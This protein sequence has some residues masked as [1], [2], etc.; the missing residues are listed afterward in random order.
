MNGGASGPG[1][2]E[3]GIDTTGLSK[4]S[5]CCG[6]VTRRNVCSF[7]SF[8]RRSSLRHSVSSPCQRYWPNA[9]AQLKLR[10]TTACN[11]SV[12]GPLQFGQY[13]PYERGPS[14][15]GLE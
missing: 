8:Q 1:T 15:R 10:P 11:Q 12:V 13:W 5:N 14:V 9:M 4:V 7:A 3:F 2:P 6:T